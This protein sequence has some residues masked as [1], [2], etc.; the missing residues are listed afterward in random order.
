MSLDALRQLG[1]SRVWISADIGSGIFPT[2]ALDLR[3]LPL[4]G[5]LARAAAQIAHVR[6]VRAGLL[7]LRLVHADSGADF[8]ALFCQRR[9]GSD[10]GHGPNLLSSLR[11]G[12]W[13]LRHNMA[14]IY[15]G[16]VFRLA[17]LDE[18]L[19]PSTPLGN[20]PCRRS[21]RFYHR[22]FN[23]RGRSALYSAARSPR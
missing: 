2:L 16:H 21:G 19:D 1:R 22:S 12:L 10:F 18:A 5:P 9:D 13:R 6:Q 17:A 7:D 14:D 3:K 11:V 20:C 23:L 4:S 8:I 15:G